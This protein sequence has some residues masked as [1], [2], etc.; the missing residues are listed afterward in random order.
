MPT[1]ATTTNL[2]D[3]IVPLCIMAGLAYFLYR[4]WTPIWAILGF[5][6]KLLLFTG[7]AA[8]ILLYCWPEALAQGFRIEGVLSHLQDSRTLRI[9]AALVGDMLQAVTSI[10]WGR[11]RLE[12]SSDEL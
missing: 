5:L 1:T 8:G 10:D 4:I 6:V 11:L 2:I 3:A 9:I 12:W 7:V